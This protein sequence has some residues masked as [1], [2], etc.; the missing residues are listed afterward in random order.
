MAGNLLIVHGGGP[1]AVINAS[2][3][4]AIRQAQDSPLV[5]RVYAAIGGT[6]GLLKEQLRDVTDLPDEALRGLLSSPAS[7][8]GTSRDALEAPEYEAMVPILEKYGIRYV[9]MNGGNGTMDTCGKLY[10]RC[11]GRD[12][13][14]IGIPKTMDN[15][16]AITDHSP[17]FGSAARY[18]AGSVAEV[19]CDV[20]G[21]PIHVVVVE[22]LGR[23]A[24]WV[25]AASALA[26]DSYTHGPD[27]IYL[28]ERAFREEEF[29]ADVEHL[30]QT[31][32]HGVVV[33]S[34][35]LHYADGTPIVEPVFTVGRATYFGDVSA[36]LANLIIRKLGYKARAE[37]PGILG[38][39]SI[40]W[41][42]D[43]DRAEAELCGRA[44]VD[45]ATAG[46]SGKMVALRRVP[47]PQYR[48][49]TFLVDIQQV[50]MT[51]RK[52]PDAFINARGNGITEAFKDWCRPLLGAPLPQLMDLRPDQG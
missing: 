25:T 3:Y 45:A 42:S 30:I 52:M 29:L 44:A 26:T 51:E 41:Q 12:I 47:G 43:T 1:T 5:D 33:A 6:G 16:L 21:L 24:G 35:G 34:E 8:I 28:P 20:E 48:C 40:A 2:L 37:K 27:L 7:A 49:E 11:A 17:G 31:K 9:L 15:D 18:M 46:E 4:G 23:N 13:R 50:M 10:A 32:G 22:A 14:V 39:A 38:R 19:C 36:H